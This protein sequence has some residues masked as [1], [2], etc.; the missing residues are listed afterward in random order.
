MAE[1][2]QLKLYNSLTRAIEP[3]STHRDFF[4]FYCCGPTV[5]GRAHIGNFRAFICADLLVR[6]LK[7][8]D[9]PVRFVRNITDVDDKT[10]RGAQQEKIPLAEFTRKHEQSFQ[11]D[12]KALSLLPPDVEPRA[13]EKTH[14]DE[15]I[16]LVGRL[17]AAKHAYIADDG[18]VYYRI[19]SFKNYGCLCHLDREGL[20]AGER[21]AQDEYEKK[22][23]ADFVLWKKHR[24]EDGDV[25]WDSP[26]GPGRPGW[27]VECSAMSMKY[28]GE[29][30]EL[31]GGGIDLLFPHHENEIAQSEGATG[32][33]FVKHWW[34]V[35][36]LLVDGRKMS[37]SLGNLYTL[38]DVRKMGFAPNFRGEM[39]QLRYALMSTH[40]R[41]S[42]NFT[43]DGLS[44]AASA[45]QRLQNFYTRLK[46]AADDGSVLGSLPREQTG[47][48]LL[49][50]FYA[51]LE[52]DLNV[53][54]ALGEL[55]ISVAEI[56]RLI[57]RRK[58]S[59]QDAKGWIE[60]LGRIDDVLK[61]GITDLEDIS[62][63]E[64]QGLISQ[65]DEAR[66]GKDWAESDRI[67]KDLE[68]RGFVVKDTPTGTKIEQRR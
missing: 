46:Y 44:A 62:L 42:M 10:I 31:H 40:Y 65:R 1:S 68:D 52:N 61:V 20:R 37:K 50:K 18:S 11:S 34:H 12:C 56:N 48:V 66:A 59:A 35:A 22:S 54:A 55:F 45:I 29:S 17:I 26:W 67:R 2:R 43:K 15:M 47:A 9:Y 36:H 6:T 28:L 58:L 57:D 19:D 63:S 41:E 32:K 33:P 25:R 30:Y 21:V 60:V 39:N 53:S 24:P 13:A 5:Y 23:L 16:R 4:G 7:A 14:I 3:L 51:A 49:E 8:F 38:E 27:H 64:I